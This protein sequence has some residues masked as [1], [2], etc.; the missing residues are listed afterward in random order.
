LELSTENQ[1]TEYAPL[2]E[3]TETLDA[4]VLKTAKLI[5]DIDKD[6]SKVKQ[7]VIVLLNVEKDIASLSRAL[8]DSGRI[9]TSFEE[10]GLDET[11]KKKESICQVL[12]SVFCS[13]FNKRIKEDF[14]IEF[15]EVPYS[16]AKRK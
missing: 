13:L 8:T 15:D 7:Y 4:K 9:K 3:D 12:P 10:C 5:P 11:P 14:G 2:Q 1:S 16:I 6:K